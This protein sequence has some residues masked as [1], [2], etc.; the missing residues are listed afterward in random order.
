LKWVREEGE[1]EDLSSDDIQNQHGIMVQ[2]LAANKKK[3]KK[4]VLDK[5]DHLSEAT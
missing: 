5:S 2:K 3:E 4:K 1:D